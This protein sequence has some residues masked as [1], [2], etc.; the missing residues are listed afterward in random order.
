MDDGA[1]KGLAMDDPDEEGETPLVMDASAVLASLL[2]EKG[3]ERVQ[4]LWGRARAGVYMSALNAGEV[5]DILLRKT[6]PALREEAGET[7]AETLLS[8]P[9]EIVPDDAALAIE[10]A[11]LR[12]RLPDEAL[13]RGDAYCIALARR[14]GG[15]VVTA[16]KPWAKLNR[17]HDLGAPIRLIR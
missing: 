15:A 11:R 10:A 14:L 7:V 13:S 16:D 6:P 8:L 5:A 17:R 9:L 2:G 12:A 3:S 4:D 1:H